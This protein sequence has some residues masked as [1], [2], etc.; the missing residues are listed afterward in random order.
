VVKVQRR[1]IIIPFTVFDAFKCASTE[2]GKY[3]ASE[4]VIRTINDKLGIVL[5]ELGLRQLIDNKTW[6]FNVS[7]H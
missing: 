1:R 2:D 3:L 6:K 4:S 7:A 5:K